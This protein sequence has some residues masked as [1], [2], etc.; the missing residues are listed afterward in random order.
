M[1]N[2]QQLS[3]LEATEKSVGCE[4]GDTSFMSLKRTSPITA[5]GPLGCLTHLQSKLPLAYR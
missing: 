5:Q 3:S 4:G 1:S 2:N